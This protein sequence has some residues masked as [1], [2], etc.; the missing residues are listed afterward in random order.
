MNVSAPF[1]ARP[2]MTTLLTIGVVLAGALGYTSL[3]VDALPRVDFPTIQ[4]SAT[5]P[6]ASPETVAASVA[7]PLE[8]QFTAIPGLEKISSTSALGAT[9][10]TLEFALDRNI[11]AAALDVQSAISKASRSLP[12]D[13]PAPPSFR[14]VNP[15]DFSILVLS[16]RSDT[17]PLYVV[18]EYAD[19]L[20]G[21]RLSM[22]QGV[23][24]VV[25]FGEQKRAVRVQ[26]DPD[27][28]AARSI[29]I[30]EVSAAIKEANVSL[31]TGTF[32]GSRRAFNIQSSGQL[33]SAREY[34]PII[35]AYR[36]GKPVRLGE[37][38]EVTDGVEN[39]KLAAWFSERNP[40][41]SVGEFPRAVVLG[42][43]RQPGA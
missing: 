43:Q 2:V 9:S 36:A 27:V 16:L 11:D 33:L 3:A 26:V 23:A 20:L 13:M 6:G 39:D 1:I 8:K 22:V 38:G 31:P 29:G 19:T 35:V 17:L 18:N 14:K 34:R 32:Q 21:Q 5:L 25:I 40:D 42:V 28:M 15:A 4:V 10:V 41:G 24:Q 12:A 30:D 37:L 7:T